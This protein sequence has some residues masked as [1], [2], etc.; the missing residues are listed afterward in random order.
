[1]WTE[2]FL[3]ILLSFFLAWIFFKVYRKYDNEKMLKNYNPETDLSKIGKDFQD[4]F[5]KKEEVKKQNATEERTGRKQGKRTNR[6]NRVSTNS[7]SDIAGSRESTEERGIL[8]PATNSIDGKTNS[9]TGKNRRLTGVLDR[10][11][12]GG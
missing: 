1:M 11:R 2:I 7:A 4:N 9:G 8:P 3:G 12:K 10:F 5:K 6:K